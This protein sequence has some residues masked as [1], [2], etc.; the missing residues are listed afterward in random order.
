MSQQQFSQQQFNF[1]QQFQEGRFYKCKVISQVNPNLVLCPGKIETFGYGYVLES[2]AEK[3]PLEFKIASKK[4]DEKNADFVL[5]GKIGNPKK[6]NYLMA[7]ELLSN[8]E[9]SL[10]IGYNKDGDTVG[11]KI[12]DTVSVQDGF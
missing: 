12:H 11:F 9:S 6:E 3:Y 1:F 10:K 5:E 7:M 2:N 4:F 8:P